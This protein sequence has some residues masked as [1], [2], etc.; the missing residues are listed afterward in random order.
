MVDLN[1]CHRIMVILIIYSRGD[2]LQ[3]RMDEFR[4][5]ISRYPLVKQ[6]VLSGRKTWQQI[7]ED[8]VLLGEQDSVF[9][10]YRGIVVSTRVVNGKIKV[11]DTIKMM[12]TNAKKR[13]LSLTISEVNA[14]MI[15]IT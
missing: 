10:P 15:I 3:S 8:W 13:K 11:G 1:I 7:Y 6:E 5:F 14:I 2:I 9:D 4:N 12:E